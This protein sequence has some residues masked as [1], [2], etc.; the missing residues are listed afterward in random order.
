MIP[1][2]FREF[3]IHAKN[4]YLTKSCSFTE[5]NGIDQHRKSYRFQRQVY[6]QVCQ[7]NS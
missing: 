5:Q 1:V 2:C 7:R 6:P 4:I 3:L